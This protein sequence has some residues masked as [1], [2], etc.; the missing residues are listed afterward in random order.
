MTSE[1][2]NKYFSWFY[3]YRELAV[4]LVIRSQ[5]HTA[6][7]VRECVTPECPETVSVAGRFFAGALKSRYTLT[8]FVTSLATPT[9]YL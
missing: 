7:A 8:Y 3:C 2:E 6:A 1:L 5:K 9:Q 4:F